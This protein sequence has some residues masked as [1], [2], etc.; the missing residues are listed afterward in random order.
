VRPVVDSA[1]AEYAARYLAAQR[2]AFDST[3]A[4][5][6]AARRKAARAA[7]RDRDG[8]GAR[9]GAPPRPSVLDRLRFPKRT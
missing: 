9:D 7:R 1:R 3:Q 6:E 8:D 5:V 2:L 4:E